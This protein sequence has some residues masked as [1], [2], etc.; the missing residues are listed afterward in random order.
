MGGSGTQDNGVDHVNGEEM[1][2][3]SAVA[4]MKDAIEWNMELLLDFYTSSTKH[5]PDQIIIFRDGV[6]ESQFNQVLNI[7]LDQIIEC[8]ANY[9]STEATDGGIQKLNRPYHSTSSIHHQ[10]SE[11]DALVNSGGT[12]HDRYALLW[13][14]QMER[15]GPMN[16]EIKQ[17]KVVKHRKHARLTKKACPEDSMS[18][19]VESFQNNEH[20]HL[21]SPVDVNRSG[22]LENNAAQY[23]VDIELS[24][25]VSFLTFRQ[26]KTICKVV[27]VETGMSTKRP[28]D[29]EIVLELDQIEKVSDIE[30]ILGY[31]SAAE[32]ELQH[33]AAEGTTL[34]KEAE[35]A[36]SNN[37]AEKRLQADPA[38]WPIMI[39]RVC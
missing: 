14:Q 33:V 37:K 9:R 3:N 31:R 35:D 6:S 7:E 17:Q 18:M 11:V 21:L 30:D 39:F 15:I 2:S 26:K 29:D 10:K 19:V 16:S 28:L 27:Q 22:R 34:V 5:K 38:T 13:N 12:L 1:D 32:H 23:S 24:C 8:N 25:L 36:A 4:A 20:V